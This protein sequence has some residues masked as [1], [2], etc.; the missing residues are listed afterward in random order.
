MKA[1]RN[2]SRLTSL[3]FLP[4]SSNDTI[5][6]KQ[7]VMGLLD[8]FGFGMK[9]LP[10]GELLQALLAARR[11]GDQ[12]RF[13]KLCRAHVDVINGAIP[14]WQKPAAEFTANPEVLNE[15]I[16]TLGMAAELLKESGHPQLL[17][18]LIG[19]PDDNPITVWER[20]LK[21]ATALA[22]ETQ[23]E[24]AA[25][26]LMNHLIDTGGLRGNAVDRL[27]ALS[28]GS[29]GHIRF[30][31]GKV[32]VAVG[33]YQQALRM[34]REQNDQEGIRVYLGNLYESQRYLGSSDLAAEYAKEL[35]QAWETAG[36]AALAKR[37]AR[38]SQIVRE[39]E[40]VLRVVAHSDGKVLELDEIELQPTMKLEMHF[41]RNRPGLPGATKRI[42]RGKEL[43][44]KRQYDE[45]L[46][47]FRE[48]ANIDPYE[49]DAHYQAGMVLCEQQLYPQAVEE[50]ETCE[51][52]APGWYFCRSDLWVAKQL[53]LGIMPHEVFLGMRF[54]QDGP[55]DTKEKMNLATRMR[56]QAET[57]PLFAF[58]FGKLLQDTG[59]PKE[60]AQL[61]RKALEGEVESDVRTRILLSL[62]PLEED[63]NKRRQLFQE[64]V[65]LNGN[66]IAA[67]G[68]ALSLRFGLQ[69]SG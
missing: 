68:A 9:Q 63:T 47:L 29:L 4:T 13:A 3:V 24:E 30:G 50:Y 37:F 14:R 32:D 18:A 52:L 40:P 60:A 67:A 34:C 8:L 53:A 64:A 57:I 22:N 38:L 7:I 61:W 48:A 59:R 2:A 15:Y 55:P 41:W 23:F 66:L 42:E 21:E 16:Q 28:Q 25:E 31:S 65:E 20:K 5:N 69:S 26:L 44:G 58:L 33:H 35:G 39:G 19:N 51:S 49:P 45:A 17:N 27:Q 54:L 1:P 62:A 6:P 10:E 56:P 11:K 46:E 43:A 12:Q 36:N